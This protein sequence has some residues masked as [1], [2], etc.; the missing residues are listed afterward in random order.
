[1]EDTSLGTAE[2][3]E[4]ALVCFQLTRS[5]DPLYSDAGGLDLFGKVAD[6]LVGVLVGVGVNVGPAARELD[7]GSGER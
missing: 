2:V 5:D 4:A 1:M 7:W 3:E 6:G